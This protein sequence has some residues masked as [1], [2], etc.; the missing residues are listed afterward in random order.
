M[1][2]KEANCHWIE[3]KVERGNEGRRGG[4]ENVKKVGA[5]EKKKDATNVLGYLNA[6]TKKDGKGCASTQ[7]GMG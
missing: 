4:F 5:F 3:S 6:T 7:T 2:F 1:N